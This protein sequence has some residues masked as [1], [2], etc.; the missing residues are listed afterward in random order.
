[1]RD[2]GPVHS[3]AHNDLTNPFGVLMSSEC[4]I[5]GYAYPCSA[6]MRKPWTCKDCMDCIILARNISSAPRQVQG[7]RSLPSKLESF[8]DGSLPRREVYIDEL[9]IHAVCLAKA[10]N[11]YPYFNGC[12][13]YMKCNVCQDT[14]HS[15]PMMKKRRA[16]TSP[17]REV[18]LNCRGTLG[19]LCANPR[20]MAMTLSLHTSSV[21]IAHESLIIALAK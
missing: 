15:K 2:P 7:N 6:S 1:M 4:N 14:E 18:R 16:G 5:S 21:R 9:A 3:T 17:G 10:C 20:A 11:V 8:A 13:R 19:N 12:L